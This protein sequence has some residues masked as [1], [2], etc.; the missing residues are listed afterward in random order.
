MIDKPLIKWVYEHRLGD[1]EV[2]SKT[3]KG[4]LIVIM[5]Y[6]NHVDPS[7][8]REAVPSPQDIIGSDEGTST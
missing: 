1:L 5:Q 8:L 3:K 4:A 6:L 2:Y 7:R